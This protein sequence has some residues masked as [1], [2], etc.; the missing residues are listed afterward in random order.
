MPVRIPLDIG[1]RLNDLRD[2]SIAV[3][4]R[5]ENESSLPRPLPMRYGINPPK[6]PA[7]G[8]MGLLELML[9][10]GLSEVAP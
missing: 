6:L 3:L 9:A 8:I 10:I 1:A 4:P 2:D 7:Y 5:G